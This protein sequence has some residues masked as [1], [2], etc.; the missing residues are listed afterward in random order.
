MDSPSPLRHRGWPSCDLHVNQIGGDLTVLQFHPHGVAGSG[1]EDIAYVDAA[2]VALDDLVDEIQAQ[3]PTVM[4]TGAARGEA[5]LEEVGEVLL[6]NVRAAVIDA[7]TRLSVLLVQ[8]ERH[9]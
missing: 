5:E 3:T 8:D 2:F 7:Q 9:R 1:R 6:G 4:L